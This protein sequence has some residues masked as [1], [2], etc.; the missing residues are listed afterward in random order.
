MKTPKIIE[1]LL[2]G[3]DG[4]L[5]FGGTKKGAYRIQLS[6]PEILISDL[7]LESIIEKANYK[8]EAKI[9]PCHFGSLSKRYNTWKILDGLNE[10]NL[11]FG[12]GRNKGQ[13]FEDYVINNLQQA[14]ENPDSSDQELYNIL[15]SHFKL[16]KKEILYFTKCSN[17]AV[18]R[19]ISGDVENCGA[20][21]SDIDCHL[22]NG[23][24]IHISLKDKTG[25]TFANGGYFGAFTVKDNTLYPSQHILDDFIVNGLGVDKEKVCSGINCYNQNKIQE[26]INETIAYDPER[27]IRYLSSA[28][29]FGYWYLKYSNL[30]KW[31]IIDLTKPEYAITL[32]G[33]IENIEVKY[34]YWLSPKS[35]SKQ[36]TANV[37][38]T[39][40]K[41][42]I[43]VRNSHGDFNPNEIKIKY[44]AK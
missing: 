40:G 36:I 35:K 1:P 19:T 5:R 37:L 23:S 8:L 24:V 2:N 16:D 28:F 31:Q 38:T 12:V 30:G 21:I 11:V 29:G 18:K 43:E 6:N 33:S 3:S 39:T 10:H 9:P 15:I 22:K 7:D 20:V 17:R 42:V 32:V 34:P 4:L 27:I 26:P 44:F 41:F 25:A 13:R 14:V